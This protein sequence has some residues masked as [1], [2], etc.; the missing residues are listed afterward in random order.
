MF[1][2]INHKNN[3]SFKIVKE[4]DSLVPRPNFFAYET[5]ERKRKREKRAW[6]PLQG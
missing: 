3:H 4:V 5:D 1:N 2:V 6:Y